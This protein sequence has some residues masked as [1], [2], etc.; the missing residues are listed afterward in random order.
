MNISI[1]QADAKD[2]ERLSQIAFAAKSYWNYP[3]EYLK[4]WKE[5][6]TITSAYIRKNTVLKAV[7]EQGKILGFGSIAFSAAL[8]AYEIGHLWVNPKYIG[9]G[10][11]HRV[12]NSLI[13][14]AQ[15]IGIK[16][17]Y[18]VSDPNA[19]GFYEKMGFVKTGS[20]SFQMG[21]EEQLDWIMTRE[22]V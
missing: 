11:G 14:Y 5:E 12:L 10:V 6:L 17:L 7:N 15:K 3:E 13:Q 8:D 4:L 22:I 20:H 18:S 1:A 9:T 2:A 16:R 19:Q 21:D